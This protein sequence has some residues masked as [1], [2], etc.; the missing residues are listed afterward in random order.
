MS[1]ANMR[2]DYSLTGPENAKAVAA[3]LV[4]AKWYAPP[5]SRGE[6]K[7]L[8]HRG[9][10]P[11][12]RDTLVWLATLFI[13]GCLGSWFWGSWAAVPFFVIYGVLHGSASDSRWHECGHGTAFKTPWMNEAV[14]Q[15]ACFMVMREPQIWRWSHTRHHTDTIIV[16]RDPEIISPRP[17]DVTSLLFNIF[18]LK[19]GVIFLKKLF[20]HAT[21]RLESDEGTFVPESERPKVYRTGRIYLAIYVAVIIACFAIGSILPAM[22]IGLPRCTDPGSSSISAARS[23]WASPRTCSTTG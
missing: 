12:I 16:G 10:K 18:G 13:S 19:N 9:D 6:L 1:L 8:M 11:A 4:S 21:G 14:Y 2:R 15:I 5:I 23:I 22:L 20:V 17:P 7:E 3:R